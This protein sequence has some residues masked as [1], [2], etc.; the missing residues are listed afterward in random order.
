MKR[1]DSTLPNMLVSLVAICAA[2]AAILGAVQWLTAPRIAERVRERQEEALRTVLPAFDNQPLDEARWYSSD[3][4][5]LARI[6]A[7]EGAALVRVYP[8]R[9]DGQAV[10]LA[11]RSYSDAGY[12]RR[13]VA[14]A[15]FLADGRLAAVTVME[16]SETPGLGSRIAGAAFLDQFTGRDLSAWRPQVKQDGG[17]VAAVAGATVSS[18]AVCEAVRRA[19]AAI[20]GGA[21]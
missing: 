20:A 17:D 19:A 4:R 16:Q 11:V 15:G 7:N 2:A 8:A 1:L 5:P 6:P 14:M 18:R 9:R 10:G 3:G 12:G 21:P 13:I